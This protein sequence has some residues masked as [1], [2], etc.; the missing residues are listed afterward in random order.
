MS[1]SVRTAR[2][3]WIK[4]LQ[5]EGKS[6]SGHGVVLDTSKQNGGFDQGASPMELVLIALAGCTAM[7]VADILRKKRQA[8]EALEIKVEATRAEEHPRVYTHIEMV[9]RLRGKALNPQAVARA[10]ELSETKYCSV[11]A[12]LGKTAHI[13]TRFEIAK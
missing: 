12:M 10:I 5:F 4:G 6:G 11:G 2:V 13:K 3:R 7:D 8:L 9:Y 1:K